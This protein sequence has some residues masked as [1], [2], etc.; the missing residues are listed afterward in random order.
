MRVNRNFVF[1]TDEDSGITGFRPTWMKA[2]SPTTGVAHDMLEHFGPSG[3]SA[4]E[5]ELLAL[6]SVLALRIEPDVFSRYK[7]QLN[8]LADLLGSVIIDAIEAEMD[9]PRP[10]SSRP[11]GQD[12][13]W[14][15]E[16][17]VAATHLAL[18]QVPETA[19]WDKDD[20]Q[21]F[22]RDCPESVRAR[23]RDPALATALIGWLRRGYRKAHA[24]YAR[25]DLYTVGSWSFKKLNEFSEKACRAEQLVEGDRVGISIDLR[26]G[27]I[28]IR[29]NGVSRDPR[30]FT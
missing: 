3:L 22:E 20:E 7:P 12:L 30:C 27:D 17:I 28:S 1:E 26:H 19:N 5:D 10:A 13:A 15:D 29:V 14:A 21:E 23:L 24:R 4:F 11:L 2:A 16:L 8:Q 18:R 9:T 6:G 25:Q